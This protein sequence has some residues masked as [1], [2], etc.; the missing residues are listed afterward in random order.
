MRR[1]GEAEREQS[2]RREERRRRRENKRIRRRAITERKS[3]KRLDKRNK[4]RDRR[5][6]RSVK[7]KYGRKAYNACTSKKY[8]HTVNDA[9]KA[10]R[11][12]EGI[13][14]RKYTVYKCNYC[15]GWHLTTHGYGGA[16]E[17]VRDPREVEVL[18]YQD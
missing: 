17:A 7:R 8:Y 3:R 1:D 2:R 9:F 18:G 10:A 5:R 6:I 15:D 13:F 12:M 11:C 16:N 4:T 14:D